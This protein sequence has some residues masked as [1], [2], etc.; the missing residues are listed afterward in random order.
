MDK[1]HFLTDEDC[2]LLLANGRQ[3][4]PVRGTGAEIDFEP[5]VKLFTP[6]GAAVW[7]LTE[8]D[9]ELPELAWGLADLGFGFAEFGSV[10]LNELAA[11]GGHARVQ[12]DPAFKGTMPLSE[13]ARQAAAEGRINA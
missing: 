9:T 4:A 10:D 1:P 2:A 11:A 13:Y 8:I 6:L 12:R 7:L 5:V 3:Q